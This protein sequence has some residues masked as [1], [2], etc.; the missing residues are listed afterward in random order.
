MFPRLPIQILTKLCSIHTKFQNICQNDALWRELLLRD[1]S[2]TVMELPI[3]NQTYQLY[4]DIAQFNNLPT[5]QKIK[6]IENILLYRITTN[7][8]NIF[9]DKLIEIYQNA[10]FNISEPTDLIERTQTMWERE[11]K[12]HILGTP[13]VRPIEDQMSAE[14]LSRTLLFSW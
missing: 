9:Y 4:Y 2:K 13:L 12:G 1:F 5:N 11:G 10:I 7:Q 8:T 14:L 6:F 3:R